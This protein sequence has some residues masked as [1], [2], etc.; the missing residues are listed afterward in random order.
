MRHERGFTTIELIVGAAIAAFAL[1][2]ALAAARQ[3][4]G[5]AA[6]ADA[7]VRQT[8]AADRLIERLVAEAASAWAVYVPPTDAYG[9][10]NS[11][12]HDVAFF[13]EDGAHR[14]YAWAYDFDV[15]TGMAT[16]VAF[17]PGTAPAAGERIGPFSTFAASSADVTALGDPLFAQA[18]APVV[19]YAFAAMP[20]AVGGNGVVSL[21]VA[22]ASVDRTV[23]LASA[24]APTTFT[25]VVNY[26]PP[27]VVFTATPS[28]LPVATL[29][30]TPPP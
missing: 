15:A 25:V 9:R 10:P 1:F 4:A 23:V 16:R 26:T 6:H 24:T 27:P 12:G 20:G 30:P 22:S 2:V 7:R 28:P 18:T 19:H 13:S 5:V 3:L 17:A 8:A 29:S 14:A 21:H 11:D